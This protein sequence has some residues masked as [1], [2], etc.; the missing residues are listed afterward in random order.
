MKKTLFILLCFVGLFV[1]NSVFAQTVTIAH[2]SIIS[3]PN[4]QVVYV[5]G[6]LTGA[7]HI[8]ITG[9]TID[10]LY[11]NNQSVRIATNVA[12]TGGSYNYSGLVPTGTQ[13]SGPYKIKVTTNRQ[14][15]A[16]ADASNCSCQ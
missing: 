8:P 1:S 16:T 9:Y 2:A 11:G 10:L 13:S 6:T 7:K 4:N 14:A 15:N 12:S 5:S 3:V